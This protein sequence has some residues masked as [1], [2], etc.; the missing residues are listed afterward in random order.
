VTKTLIYLLLCT[1]EDDIKD[2]DVSDCLQLLFDS[3][4]VIIA[5]KEVLEV[6]PVRDLV[7]LKFFVLLSDLLLVV[8]VFV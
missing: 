1:L 4:F 8:G 3:R 5:F 2:L 6:L 7:E